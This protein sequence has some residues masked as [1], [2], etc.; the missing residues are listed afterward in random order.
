MV[1]RGVS[2]KGKRPKGAQRFVLLV[3]VILDLFNNLQKIGDDALLFQQQSLINKVKVLSYL[4][5]LF[6]SSP[7]FL[8]SHFFSGIIALPTSVMGDTTPLH[9]RLVILSVVGIPGFLKLSFFFFP[10]LPQILKY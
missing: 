9:V 7:F 10:P 4:F 3:F 1:P 5:V 8:L 6:I 2:P